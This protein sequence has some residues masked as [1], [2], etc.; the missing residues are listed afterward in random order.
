MNVKGTLPFQPLEVP[1]CRGVGWDGPGG[2]VGVVWWCG[3][4]WCGV[5]VGS[6]ATI[7]PLLCSI[8]PA[9]V[10]SV[11]CQTTP[12]QKYQWM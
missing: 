3:V 6:L 8:V 12:I 10:A 7:G 9:H 5:V 2:E 11:T 1:H 4:V